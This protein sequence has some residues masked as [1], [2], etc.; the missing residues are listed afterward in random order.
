MPSEALPTNPNVAPSAARN[1]GPKA[2]GGAGQGRAEG[3]SGGGQGEG[4]SGGTR[5][6]RE[7]YDVTCAACGAATT[8]PFKPITGRP[9]YCRDCFRTKRRQTP[10]RSADV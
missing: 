1:A 2:A 6:P 9:V 8:V 4:G 3:N 7:S 5:P 10:K